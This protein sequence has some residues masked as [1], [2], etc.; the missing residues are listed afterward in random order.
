MYTAMDI[1]EKTSS[2][3]KTFICSANLTDQRSSNNYE[4]VRFIAKLHPLKNV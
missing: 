1:S 3:R 2:F 4:T